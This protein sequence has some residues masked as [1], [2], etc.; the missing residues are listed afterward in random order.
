[1]SRQWFGWG[2]WQEVCNAL[3][4]E[5]KPSVPK[6]GNEA[7]KKFQREKFAKCRDCG[8]QMTYVGGNIFV[9]DNEVEKTFTT[10]DESG[11][12]VKKTEKRRCGNIN[13]VDDQYMGYVE[14]LFEQ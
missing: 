9:C 2:K 14:Y 10:T 11:I 13:L 7:R 3:G 1:M 6:Q 5:Y 8:G 4:I 12:E